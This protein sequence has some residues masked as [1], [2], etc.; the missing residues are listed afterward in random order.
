MT[1]IHVPARRSLVVMSSM[2]SRKRLEITPRP[3][4]SRNSPPFLPPSK[5]RSSPSSCSSCASMYSAS[6]H[7]ILVGSGSSPAATALEWHPP[8]S[9]QSP[10]PLNLPA[11][12]LLLTTASRTLSLSAVP[13]VNIVWR[14][15]PAGRLAGG[16]TPAAATGAARIL[17]SAA[18]AEVGSANSRGDAS[19]SLPSLHH[20][21]DAG[22]EGIA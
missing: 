17:D 22:V 15:W 21:H 8:S 10:P 19:G 2:S 4:A 3:S 7:R 9:S 1:S 5:Y 18:R 6:L 11:M 20:S 13:R 12:N 16:V 14:G